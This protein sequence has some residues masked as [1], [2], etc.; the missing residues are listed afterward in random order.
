MPN[1]FFL[2]KELIQKII[3]SAGDTIVSAINKTLGSTTWQSGGGGG[4]GGGITDGDKGDITVSGSGTT[5]TIDNDVVTFA[6]LQ[7][8]SQNNFIG[9]TSAGSGDPQQVSAS[10]ARTILSINNVDNT[11]DLNKPISTATSTALAGKANTSHTHS[12]SDITNFNEVVE[13]TIG[14]KIIAGTNVTVSYNDISGETIISAS[15]GG[16]SPAGSTGQIQFN[17]AG[18]FGADANFFWD[19]T[20]N[21]L[22]VGTSSPTA[23]LDIRAV[24]A[25]GI[26]VL[27][28]RSTI[29][30]T[31]ATVEFYSHTANP[32][33]TLKQH[34][35]TAASGII[36]NVS[37][38]NGLTS[39]SL[40]SNSA[41]SSASALTINSGN[42]VIGYDGGATKA[43]F[44][45][46][47]PA[48][49]SFGV[50][51]I[52]RLNISTAGA[53]LINGFTSST[54]G[55]TVKGA[56][57]QTANLTEWQNSAGTALTTISSDGII[58]SA[59]PNFHNLGGSLVGS[60]V[61]WGARWKWSGGGNGLGM[62]LTSILPASYTPFMSL[63]EY[64]YSGWT[65]L[66]FAETSTTGI[67]LKPSGQRLLSRNAADTAYAPITCGARVASD[68]GFVVQ[69]AASQT[70]NLQEWQNSAGTVL[71]KVAA[72]GITTFTDY[73]YGTSA[74]FS[75]LGAFGGIGVGAAT[76]A[77]GCLNASVKGQ[78]IRGAASQSANLQEWQN[79]AGTALAFVDSVGKI[80]SNANI[81]AGTGSGPVTFE[82]G[83][84]GY[85]FSYNSNGE[86]IA[87]INQTARVALGINVRVGSNG[88][89][90]WGNAAHAG[91]NATT[92]TALSRNAAGVVE[93]NNGTAGTYRDL[94]V[95]DIISSGI[96]SSNRFRGAVSTET[97]NATPSINIDNVSAH[98]ITALA[99]D[100]T[101][102]T[103]TG[104][105][106]N[107]DKLLI[108]IKDNGTAR[109]IT[110]GASF[111]AK[112]VALPTTTVISKVLTVGFIYD[113]VSAKWGCIASAQEA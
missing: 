20:N 45:T 39:I 43:Y 26:P 49:L 63:G 87:T 32:I 113:T 101:S 72:D 21:R 110:W 108:R 58:S 62:A 88:A 10:Q 66:F 22:G 91:S 103:I 67:R 97:S 84:V 102:V 23:T 18:A 53:V 12:I 17:N 48:A 55:F 44:Q 94:K 92:D 6:K 80:R 27:A 98:S 40:S 60:D 89:F 8:I 78:I 50:N 79:S 3:A 14:T 38:I 59:A 29:D 19:D 51:N 64:G 107:F 31:S 34:P 106:S 11:S 28:A 9:R 81:M 112:G 37:Q 99:A 46:Q 83:F 4:G 100:I 75:A 76:L 109:A 85:G 73:I 93:I 36:T 65:Y 69:G 24:P 16:G 68:I 61:I 33:F 47:L 57:S 82:M 90:T 1:Q 25:P 30:T 42:L 71:V 54:V 77:V 105:P 15:G 2:K 104:T 56:A 96:V 7:N 41:A 111:E 5:W 13:D 74:Q 52:E 95:R 70:A 35:S 86:P